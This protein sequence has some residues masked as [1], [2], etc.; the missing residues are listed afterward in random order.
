[1]CISVYVVAVDPFTI[2][3]MYLVPISTSGSSTTSRRACPNINTFT[4][5]LTLSP[6]W[7][8][9]VL[10]FPHRSQKNEPHLVI[11]LEFLNVK[12]FLRNVEFFT[13]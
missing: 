8:G 11:S 5:F 12:K 7:L 6:T 13:R 1:M 9:R 3:L 2:K 4:I 10:E